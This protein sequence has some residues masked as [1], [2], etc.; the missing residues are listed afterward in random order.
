M[1]VRVTDCRTVDSYVGMV[2]G[3][4]SS[5]LSEISSH[6]M[7]AIS[8]TTYIVFDVT[9]NLAQSVTKWRNLTKEESMS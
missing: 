9:L 5:G 4:A 7:T 8:D 2:C 1:K 3:S 6:Q